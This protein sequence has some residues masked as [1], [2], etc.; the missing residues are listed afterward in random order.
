MMASTKKTPVLMKQSPVAKDKQELTDS[1][2][3]ELWIEESAYFMAESRGFIL[4]FE[5]ED[6]ETATK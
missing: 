5:R 4:G 6:W 1:I 2:E 3:R